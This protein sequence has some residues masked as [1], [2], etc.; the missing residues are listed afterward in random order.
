MTIA[1][2]AAADKR[3]IAST[4]SI[5][6]S[7]EFLAIQLIYGGKTIESLPR[8]K[9]PE[10]FSLSVNEK[11]FSNRMEAARFL[12]KIIVAY[13]KKKRENKSL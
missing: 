1:A 13:I 12:D 11:H 4:F 5:F 8:Y 2:A 7:G 10:G 6:L 3:S 9:F